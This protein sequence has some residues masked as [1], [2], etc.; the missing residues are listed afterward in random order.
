[1]YRLSDT[2]DA[3]VVS[4]PP[5]GAEAVRS[6][7]D[8]LLLFEDFAPESAEVLRWNLPSTATSPPAPHP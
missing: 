3:F 4:G 8:P 1:M 7:S 5:Y 6:Y 2:S